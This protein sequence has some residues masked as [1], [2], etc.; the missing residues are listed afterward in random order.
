MDTTQTHVTETSQIPHD[1]QSQYNA[2]KALVTIHELLSQTP[3][4]R[5]YWNTVN[6]SIKFIE[7]LHRQS[8][9]EL[10][11]HPEVNLIP[12]MKE[13]LAKKAEVADEF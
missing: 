4:P 7:D 12:E 13:R 11:K 9:L 2:T 1:L 3:F 5:T 8:Y 10:E 6:S